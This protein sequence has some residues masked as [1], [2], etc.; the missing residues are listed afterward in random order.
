MLLYLEWGL[1]SL[2]AL[3]ELFPKPLQDSYQPWLTIPF[4]LCFALLG[5]RLPLR[6]Q[7]LK[8]GYTILGIGLVALVVSFSPIRMFPF[9]YVPLV[10]RSCLIFQWPGRIIVTTVVLGLFEISLIRRVNQIVLFPLPAGSR[11][12]FLLTF[13]LLFA[14]SLIFLLLLMQTL[15]TERQSRDQLIVA[16]H[17]LQQYAR[18]VEG[19]ATAQERNRIARDIHDSLGHALTALNVQ[20]EGAL[21]LWSTQPDQAHKF[22]E[23]AKRL[24]S[25]ALQEVRQSV[26]ALRQDPL[27]NRDLKS[28]LLQLGQ[29]FYNATGIQPDYQLRCAGDL[30]P[31]VTTAVYRIVQEALNNACKHAAATRVTI[32][33]EQSRETLS[34]SIEDNGQGFDPAQTTT[35]FGL[36]GMQE[37][38]LAL[39]GR[40]DLR[41]QP[42]CGCRIRVEIPLHQPLPTQPKF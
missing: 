19:L 11:L 25:T 14:L 42:A 1:L 34:L 23:E 29:D 27:H 24:G 31:E 35:G 8:G 3:I 10:M 37:R 39:G 22:V 16:H 33:L 40:W 36:Q 4:I 20:L 32:Q 2:A 30:S 13:S 28:S 26:S 9:L 38:T 41:T 12:F 15:L 7:L 17:Q 18:R 21:K 5:L 6:R